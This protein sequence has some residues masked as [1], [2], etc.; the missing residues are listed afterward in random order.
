MYLFKLILCFLAFFFK[1]VLA[2]FTFKPTFILLNMI[3]KFDLVSLIFNLLLH[4][5]KLKLVSPDDSRFD[6]DKIEVW[7]GSKFESNVLD[8]FVNSWPLKFFWLVSKL[9]FCHLSFLI[10]CEC[11]GKATRCYFDQKLFD[12]TGL[13][14]HCIECQDNT[15]GPN[16]DKCKKGYFA[17][18]SG[19]CIACN[20]DII[21]KLI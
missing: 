21:G 9:K 12:Q 5:Y 4:F 13:G 1:L 8:C 19:R 10:A 15:D 18:N 7:N 16:C 11:N 14:G 20:C 17:Y 2:C 3:V 6:N